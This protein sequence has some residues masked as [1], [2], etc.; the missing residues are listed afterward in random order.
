MLKFR[1]EEA[2]AVLAK[3]MEGG[4]GSEKEELL[5]PGPFEIPA[6]LEIPAEAMKRDGGE[7]KPSGE[8]A[9]RSRLWIWLVWL[10]MS[11][12]VPL[13]TLSSLSHCVKHNIHL[14]CRWQCQNRWR[15]QG[16][17]TSML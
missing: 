5:F 8:E 16:G 7:R 14:L 11:L 3:A 1:D 10:I 17:A 15:F 12:S 2:E 13:P 4:G 9:R 6:P